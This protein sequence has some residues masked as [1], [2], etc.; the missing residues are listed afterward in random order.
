MK[1]FS[2]RD[3]YGFTDIDRLYKTFILIGVFSFI[4]SLV[5]GWF[6]NDFYRY[7]AE[8]WRKAALCDEIQCDS[9]K[10][11]IDSFPKIK[12]KETE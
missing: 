12:I 10:A 11:G 4:I 3:V 6:S 9:L 1:R 7:C 2:E 5:I 8:T